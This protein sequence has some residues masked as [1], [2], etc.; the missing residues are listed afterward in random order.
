MKQNESTGKYVNG[1]YFGN[2][3]LIIL[4]EI[5]VDLLEKTIND[6]IKDRP[7]FDLGDVFQEIN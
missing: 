3:G 6:F 4:K 7:Y 2:L 5:S 1:S